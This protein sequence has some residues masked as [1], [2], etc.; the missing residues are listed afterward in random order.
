MLLTIP[1]NTVPLI[2]LGLAWWFYQKESSSL[3]S[4]RRRVFILALVANAVSAVV[5]LSFLVQ[6]YIASRGTQ[7]VDL[8][9]A[10]PVISMLGVGLL[11]AVLAVSGRRVSRLVLVGNGLLTAAL[12]YFAAMGASI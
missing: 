7:P 5:L 6:V 9:R 1:L 3:V 2:L 4:W 12:W 10:Y 11:A 8:D